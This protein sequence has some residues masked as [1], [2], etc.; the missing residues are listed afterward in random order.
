MNK[1]FKV[2]IAIASMT[3]SMALTSLAGQWVNNGGSWSYMTDD[4]NFA[5]NTL[6]WLDENHDTYAE[7]YHFD[8]NGVMSQGTKVTMNEYTSDGPEKLVLNIDGN[9]AATDYTLDCF[10][11]TGNAALGKRSFPTN[12]SINVDDKGDY[13]YAM[14]VDHYDFKEIK[15]ANANNY[16]NFKEAIK[17]T[18]DGY[19]ADVSLIVFADDSE[20]VIMGEICCSIKATAKFTD[21][22]TV[23]S[24][25]YYNESR[26]ISEYLKTSGYDNYMIVNSVNAD[27]YIT[28]CSI[29]GVG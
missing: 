26:S 27:G 29:F 16:G 4:G 18:G 9:G 12:Y 6:L 24:D 14:N 17:K 7:L 2:L 11:G 20:S 21:N 13:V 1:N 25:P 15:N 23:R 5:K 28:D 10:F 22:C 8:A 3:C 19:S